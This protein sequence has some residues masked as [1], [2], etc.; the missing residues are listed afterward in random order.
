MIA[1]VLV[2]IRFRVLAEQLT[3]SVQRFQDAMQRVI[4]ESERRAAQ[5]AW[6]EELFLPDADFP[7]DSAPEVQR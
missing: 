4:A 7:R 5:R 6:R 1:P 2:E 3:A